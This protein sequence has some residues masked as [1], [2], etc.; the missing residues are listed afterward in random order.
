MEVAEFKNMQ[1][2]KL[3]RARSNLFGECGSSVCI[4]VKYWTL[5]VKS[6]KVRDSV[7]TNKGN[8]GVIFLLDICGR[9]ALFFSLSR[10]GLSP[11]ERPSCTCA[12]PSP[13]PAVALCPR[14]RPQL[15]IRSR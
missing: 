12:S 10:H 1:L 7:S 5:K 2:V 9:A 15:R 8:K 14:A 6:F 4:Y 11:Q 3:V 13:S